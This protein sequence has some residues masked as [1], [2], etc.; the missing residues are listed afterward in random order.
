MGW[1]KAPAYLAVWWAGQ[2]FGRTTY[3][4]AGP[5]AFFAGILLLQVVVST[6]LV[7]LLSALDGLYFRGLLPA[8]VARFRMVAHRPPPPHTLARMAAVVLRN[9]VLS[10]LLV[11]W[12]LPSRP[13]DFW[14]AHDSSPASTLALS[15]GYAL[16]FEVFFYAGHRL[17]HWRPV[18]GAL[19]HAL[20]HQ[21]HTDSAVS[22]GYMGAVDYMLETNVPALVPLYIVGVHVPAYTGF[23]AVGLFNAILVHSGWNFPWL[24]DPTRHSVHHSRPSLNLGNGPLDYLLGTA[25]PD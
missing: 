2:T 9:Q 17:L 10:G 13:P 7:G 20:H 5:R 6:V 3:V 21:T 24:A 16:L 23:L 1:Q 15:A 4:S 8:C 25:G 12:T 11:L 22:F 19:G 18:Y 14:P